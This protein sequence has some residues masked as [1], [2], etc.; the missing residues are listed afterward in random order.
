LQEALKN[1]DGIQN[2]LDKIYDEV[3][4]FV[5]IQS[6]RTV[7]VT[8]GVNLSPCI[9]EAIALL[10]VEGDLTRQTVVRVRL[11]DL[12]PV[13]VKKQELTIVLKILIEN[14]FRYLPPEEEINLMAEKLEKR[15]KII[16]T[17]ESIGSVTREDKSFEEQSQSI[18]LK[19]EEISFLS[20]N[21]TFAKDCVGAWG[22]EIGYED[23]GGRGKFWFTL[24]VFKNGV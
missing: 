2:T 22:G 13:E 24:P 15:V 14:T 5:H 11:P 21:L 1:I 4:T 20:F 8:E 10:P 7:A 17:S 9:D 18:G 12:P 3:K 19:E 16:I 23:D 6:E